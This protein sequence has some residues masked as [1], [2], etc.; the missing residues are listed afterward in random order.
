LTKTSLGSSL[1]S[2]VIYVLERIIAKPK[3]TSKL[4]QRPP[5][6]L[7]YDIVAEVA[8]VTLYGAELITEFSTAPTDK[9]AK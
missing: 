4:L 1:L 6:K 2:L 9:S 3:L 8:D 7:I 5:F